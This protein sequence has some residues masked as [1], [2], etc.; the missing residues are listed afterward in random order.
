MANANNYDDCG[1]ADDGSGL[2]R[3]TAG[4]PCDNGGEADTGINVDYEGQPRPATP[5]TAPDMGA[6]EIVATP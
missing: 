4:S 1:L 2:Y 3:F 6:D 5:G